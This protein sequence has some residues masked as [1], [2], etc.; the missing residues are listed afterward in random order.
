MS[1]YPQQKITCNWDC[2]ALLS[3]QV[4]EVE[5]TYRKEASASPTQI[6]FASVQASG[7]PVREAGVNIACS[8]HSTAGR[9]QGDAL[10]LTSHSKR[11]P[12]GVPSWHTNPAGNIT[13]S[14][15]Q[16]IIDPPLKPSSHKKT[17]IF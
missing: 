10:L 16:I 1:L 9:M 5:A 13:T 7:T 2:G 14:T 8:S 3:P 15:E 12:T 4:M 11:I 6:L 17:R